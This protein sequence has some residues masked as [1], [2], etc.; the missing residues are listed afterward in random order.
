MSHRDDPRET[1]WIVFE[2]ERSWFSRCKMLIL[3]SQFIA[4]LELT[5]V[6]SNGRLSVIKIA[7]FWTACTSNRDGQTMSAISL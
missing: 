6:V 3:E 5:L 1:G 2:I 4:K 7:T